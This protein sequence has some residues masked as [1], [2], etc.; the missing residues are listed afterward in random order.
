VRPSDGVI[1]GTVQLAAGELAAALLPGGR[2]PLSGLGRAAIDTLPGP[3]VDV[4][5][6]TVRS[7]DKALLTASLVGGVLGVGALGGAR[8]VGALPGAALLGSLGLVSGVAAASRPDAGTAASLAAGATAGA[9]GALAGLLLRSRHDPALRP[10]LAG[11]AAG[12]GATARRLRMGQHRRVEVR[13]GSIALPAPRHPARELPSGAQFELG[14]L[15]PLFT[16]A[17]SFYVTDVQLPAPHI[18]A[19]RWRLRVTGMVD[20]PLELSMTD[21]LEMSLAELDATLVC[22]HNPVGGDRISS[23]RWLGVPLA[24]LLDRAGVQPDAQQLV[25]R[26]VD[27]FTAGIPVDHLRRGEPAL[28]AL[29]FGG[30]PLRVA[31]GF[32]ARV[33]CP[34]LWGA[35]AN[36][37]WVSEV[38]LTTWGAVRDYWDR[39]GWPRTPSR[40]RPGSRIDV[41]ANRALVRT[42][43]IFVAGV[44]WAPPAG[45]E[46]V[47]VS[48]DGTAWRPAEI[49]AE[50]APT[51][52]R[53]WRLTW[54]AEA[55]EHRLR[56]RALGRRGQQRGHEAPPYPVGSSGYHEVRVLAVDHEPATIETVRA[57]LRAHADDLRGRGA[58]AALGVRA[59]RGRGFPPAPRFPAPPVRDGT[60]L[61]SDHPL[62]PSAARP[63]S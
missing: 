35:D 31:N 54:D 43:P 52:W 32:P 55:G 49:S 38:E 14:G 59:W 45:V 26:S 25:T 46:A 4:T 34:G 12:A 44:A 60:A 19:D 42:G 16:P 57:R 27:G 62:A 11:L 8:R 58:L 36:T 13:R 22:V 61:R 15:S 10:L 40:V 50:V 28:L 2:S 18:D 39:R 29:A 30:E 9:A 17:D 6:A 56:A 63:A 48:I 41:P 7:R 21:L 5:V 51:M 33:L 47:E 24:E 37:K 1:A 53:Q 20:R 3:G 23:G